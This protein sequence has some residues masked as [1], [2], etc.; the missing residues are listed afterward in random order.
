MTDVDKFLYGDRSGVN[1]PLAQADWASKKLVWV[2]SDKL[3]F[4]PGSLKEEHGDE[5]TVELTDSGRKVG[6]GVERAA[7]G[8]GDGTGDTPSHWRPLLSGR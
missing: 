4:E 8:A 6:V 3:G 5:C 1:N 7:V 2:P